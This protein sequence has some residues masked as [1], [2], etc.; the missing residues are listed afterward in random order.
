MASAIS[1]KP[2]PRSAH[3]KYLGGT[4]SRGRLAATLATP[5]LDR[6]AKK[7]DASLALSP[8]YA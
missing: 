8:M 7:H 3:A 5:K 6:N 2:A 4:E 1:T